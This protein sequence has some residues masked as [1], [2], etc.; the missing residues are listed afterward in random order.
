MTSRRSLR[1]LDAL[2]FFVADVQTGFGPFVAIYLTSSGW[3]ETE[4][5]QALSLGTIAAMASQLPGGAFVDRLRDK[6]L[7][8]A[9]AG[10][11]VAAS[12]ILFAIAPTKRAVMTAEILHSFS[13]SM[14]GPALAAI[15]LALVGQA[16]LG[17]RLGRNARFASLGNGAAAGLL[18]LCGAYLSSRAVFWATAALMVP[19]LVA[20]RLIRRDELVHG[21]S[22]SHLN[23]PKA[24][25]IADLRGLLADPRVTGFAICVALFHLANAAIMPLAASALTRSHGDAA[26]LIIAACVVVPQALVALIAPWVGRQADRHGTRVVLALGFS[27]VPLRALLFSTI[28]QAPAIVAIQILDGVSAATFGVVVPL[29]AAHLTRG[30]ERFNLCL[31]V[32]GL[33]TATG[34]TLSTFLAGMIADRLGQSAAY[35]ALA[36]FGATAV[37]TALVVGPDRAPASLPVC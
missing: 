17:E 31:G 16:V 36:A 2:T 33:A 14:L 12:A 30:S 5:G 23:R 32:F 19:A 15:S 1:S 4:I 3:T 35:L 7:A 27:A 10:V 24:T 18:G 9:L 29:V 8:A 22:P 21:Q 13:S 11:A 26:N 28:S 20:L 37:L 6:R 25:P 34:A